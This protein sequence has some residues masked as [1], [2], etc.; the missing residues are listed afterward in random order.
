MQQLATCLRTLA[1][2]SHCPNKSSFLQEKVGL[3]VKWVRCWIISIIGRWFPATAGSPGCWAGMTAWDCSGLIQTPGVKPGESLLEVAGRLFVRPSLKVALLQYGTFG[4]RCSQEPGPHCCSKRELKVADF[5]WV[6][7]SLPF[8]PRHFC[9]LAEAFER[10]EETFC[11]HQEPDL[12]II[13]GTKNQPTMFSLVLICQ[14][15]T[16]WWPRFF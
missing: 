13:A 10:N 14:E 12:A 6:G 7:A 11:L 2:R 3:V 9:F 15:K 4:T 16:A 1:P 8:G 5:D